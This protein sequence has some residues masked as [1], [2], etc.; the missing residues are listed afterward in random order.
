M[1]VRDTVAVRHK[2]F[3]LAIDIDLIGEKEVLGAV[4][5]SDRRRQVLPKVHNWLQV[6]TELKNRC[7]QDIFIAWY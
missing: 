6:V 5:R 3:Y 1:S 7:V 2:A 4:D